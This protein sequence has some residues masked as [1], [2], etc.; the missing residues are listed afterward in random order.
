VKLFLKKNFFSFPEILAMNQ[1][2]QFHS[3]QQLSTKLNISKPTL[4]FWEK[5]F[6]GILLHLRITAVRDATHLSMSQLS[7]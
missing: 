2:K 5:E 7:A 1:K 4:H 6:E 3:I